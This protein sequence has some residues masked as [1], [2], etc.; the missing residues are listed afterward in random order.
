MTA[1]TLLVV[2]DDAAVRRSLRR[3]LERAGYAVEEAADGQEALE[4]L[5]D[6]RAA[7][8]ILDVAMP[9]LDGWH[10]LARIRA[11]SDVPVMMLSTHDAEIEQV[12]GL[13]G[14]ADA[15]LPKPI[16]A[17]ELVARV[18]AL[19][20]R[21]PPAPSVET[22]Y[23]DGWLQADLA[24]GAVTAG[25]RAV[26]LS[27]LELRMLAALVRHAGRVVSRERLEEL[28]WGRAAPSGGSVRLYVRY[29][30][31]KLGDGPGGRSPIEN[32]RGFGY[33]YVPPAS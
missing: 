8:V 6:L 9:R 14:G 2:D 1:A 4:R 18:E 24:G 27:P 23:A 21:A 10:T 12:R 22:R 29:L 33:R 25:G 16:G 19:L 15:Y 5:A 31:A 26:S 17:R 3:V 13:R 11:V 32:V 7:L 28:V 20:R 30:R